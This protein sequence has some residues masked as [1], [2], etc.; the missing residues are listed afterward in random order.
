MSVEKGFAPTHL[1]EE[2]SSGKSSLVL[3]VATQPCVGRMAL[4]NLTDTRPVLGDGGGC[5]KI[6]S[7]EQ[8]GPV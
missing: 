1:I 2:F 7:V 3:G 8:K 6:S 4:G 5:K